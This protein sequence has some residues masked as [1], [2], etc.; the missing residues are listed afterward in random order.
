MAPIGS[1][2]IQSPASVGPQGPTGPSATGPTGPDGAIGVTG[3][4]GATGTYVVSGSRDND[5]LYLTLSDGTILTLSGLHGPTGDVGS[6]SGV[7]LGGGVTVFK[8]V[9]GNTFW[10]KGISADG[11]LS[12]TETSDVINIIGSQVIQEATTVNGST[13]GVY[14]YLDGSSSIVDAGITFEEGTIV[15]GPTAAGNSASFDPEERI[16]KVPPV[17]RDEIVDIYGAPCHEGNCVGREAGDGIELAVTGGSVFDV[18]CPIGFSGITGDF[19]TNE[20]I[21]FTMILRDNDIWKLPSNFAFNESSKFFSCG[22]D[23][24]NVMSTNSGTTWIMNISSRGYGTEE[25]ESTYGIG[26]CCFVG[27]DGG[28]SCK[29]FITREECES[30]Y[31]NSYWNPLSSCAENCG[32]TGSGVCCSPGGDWGQFPNEGICQND[33]GADECRYFYGNYYSTYNYI[34]RDPDNNDYRLVELLIDSESRDIQCGGNLPCFDHLTGDD[35]CI[36][37]QGDL[38]GYEGIFQ[39]NICP[40]ACPETT[41]ACCKNGICI[42]DSTG[43]VGVGYISATLCRYVYGGIPVPNANCGNVDCCDAI[44]Y[45]GACC[46]PDNPTNPCEIQTH[47]ECYDDGGTFMGPN[48]QC[49]TVNCCEDEEVALCCLTNDY[50]DCCGHDYW[51]NTNCCRNLTKTECNSIGGGYVSGKLCDNTENECSC[52]AS[53]E[54]AYRTTPPSTSSS[55]SSSSSSS[56][57]TTPDPEEPEGA[58]CFDETG[59]TVITEEICVEDI[60]GEYLGDGTDCANSPCVIL[61]A[62]CDRSGGGWLGGTPY[63]TCVNDVTEENCYAD[64]VLGVDYSTNT[65]NYR[66]HRRRKMWGRGQVCPSGGPDQDTPINGEE[67]DCWG[68]GACCSPPKLEFISWPE[69]YKS[70]ECDIL[71]NCDIPGPNPG[72]CCH[73]YWWW[74]GVLMD[75]CFYGGRCTTERYYSHMGHD[76]DEFDVCSQPNQINPGNCTEAEREAA[77]TDVAICTEDQVDAGLHGCVVV[78]QHVSCPRGP[79]KSPTDCDSGFFN[80]KVVPPTG[81]FGGTKRTDCVYIPDLPGD[82]SLLTGFE[83]KLCNGNVVRRSG[84]FTPLWADLGREWMNEV[85]EPCSVY[86]HFERGCGKE[87]GS[88]CSHNFGGTCGACSMKQI[89][90]DV[91]HVPWAGDVYPGRLKGNYGRETF[92]CSHSIGYRPHH[93]GGPDC[94]GAEVSEVCPWQRFKG[95]CCWDHINSPTGS[96]CADAYSDEVCVTEGCWAG[97]TTNPCCTHP[98]PGPG[99]EPLDECCGEKDPSDTTK[100]TRPPGGGGDGGVGGGGGAGGDGGD[101]STTTTDPPP[102]TTTLPTTLPPCC[103]QD[104]PPPECYCGA[105]RNMGDMP[106]SGKRSTSKRTK[107]KLPSGECVYVACAPPNCPDYP[108]CDT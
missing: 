55:S 5:Y 33:V 3:A 102:G 69:C 62:C 12:V 4:T 37:G 60:G 48:T 101:G 79:M 15:F 30:N 96:C 57:T 11:S 61:G 106:V 14:A 68:G 19:N 45:Q 17:E 2:T 35:R 66:R 59:C 67:I 27:D 84:D 32:L 80:N 29:D 41:V 92:M 36:E 56:T 52:G 18:Q 89:C 50:C 65:L 104:I 77:C 9:T 82:M 86:D 47:K 44:V 20:A 40:L 95:Q 103:A 8:E 53:V 25:C 26:S 93:E 34:E 87:K 13:S 107:L 16:I 39:N 31:N 97:M 99:C 23:I 38:L 28:S 64:Q 108:P 100:P 73:E 78:G 63:V 70:D 81:M 6:A 10:F 46:Y 1:S 83:R 98:C 42:G 43:D 91:M 21:T 72:G 76:I 49:T 88:C 90:T 75:D 71:N 7:N 54:C 22:V 105:P 74:T 58:C 24:I 94:G 85:N 51:D